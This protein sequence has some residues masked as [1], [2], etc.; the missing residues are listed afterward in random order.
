MK[1]VAK[2]EDHIISYKLNVDVNCLQTKL[3]LQKNLDRIFWVVISC[4]SGGLHLKE[5]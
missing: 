1:I 3:S 5:G 4:F 2:L